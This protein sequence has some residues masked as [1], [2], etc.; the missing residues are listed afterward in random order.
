MR[1]VYKSVDE[2]IVFET[3]DVVDEDANEVRTRRNG[4]MV[5]LGPASLEED[6]GWTNYT[7]YLTMK[8]NAYMVGYQEWVWSDA[9]GLYKCL[10]G[11]AD[12]EM[13]RQEENGGVIL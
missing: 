13:S 12:V 3:I 8:S 1:I 7:I 11:T 9:S 2:G 6:G 5:T 10:N 4:N